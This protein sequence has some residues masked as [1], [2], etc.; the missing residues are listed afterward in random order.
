M[1]ETSLTFNQWKQKY[2]PR[3]SGEDYDLQGA[4]EAGI[5]PSANQHFPDTFK[6]PNHPT[7]SIESKY[8]KPGLPAG[9]W[10]GETFIPMDAKTAEAWVKAHPPQGEINHKDL[11]SMWEQVGEFLKSLGL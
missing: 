2:A 1:A 3:D 10:E 7:F 6:K 9:R 4:Y 8:W 5:V 11:Q